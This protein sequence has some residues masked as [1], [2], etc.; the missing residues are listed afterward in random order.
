MDSNRE[1][2]NG[3]SVKKTDRIVRFCKMCDERL[4]CKLCDKTFDKKKKPLET[5]SFHLI[6]KDLTRFER[7]NAKRK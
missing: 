4:G 2:P 3:C 1:N 6:K 5:T 7:D